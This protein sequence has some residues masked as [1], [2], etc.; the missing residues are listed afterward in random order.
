MID[1]LHELGLSDLAIGGIAG[2]SITLL[3]L[4]IVGPFLDLTKVDLRRSKAEELADEVR[5]RLEDE[6][7]EP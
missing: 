2:G 4:W 6:R 3:G 5:E 7:R 1:A